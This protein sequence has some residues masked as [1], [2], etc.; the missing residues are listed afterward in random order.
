MAKKS[1]KPGTRAE[2]DALTFAP[3]T[4]SFEWDSDEWVATL[5]AQLRV[6]T[7]LLKHDQQSLA[8][9]MTKLVQEGVVQDMHDHWCIARDR[10]DELAGL[11][12]VIL[13]RSFLV[14][15]RLGYCPD[16]PESTRH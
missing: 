10:L 11:L 15:E 12:D 13:L 16:R 4:P 2:R 8:D 14:L 7:T 6:A 9:E 5:L 1:E 3:V